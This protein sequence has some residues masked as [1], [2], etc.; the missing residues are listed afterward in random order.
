MSHYHSLADFDFDLPQDCIALHPASPRDSSRLLCVKPGAPFADHRFGDLPN[1]LRSG[2]LLVF[3][4]TRV[5]SARLI[6]QRVRGENRVNI[7]A[8]LLKRL[9]SNVWSAFAKPGK[10]LAIGDRVVF[11]NP[12]PVCAAAELVGT[13]RAKG[14]GGVVEIEFTR[15]GAYLDEAI[16]L[17]GAMPLPPYI[18]EA[19]RRSE[20]P[21]KNAP[22][23]TGRD[24][25]DYQTVFA[26]TDGAVAAPTASLHFTPELIAR[27]EA[28]GIAHTFVTLHVGAGTFLPVKDDNLEAHRMHAEWGEISAASAARINAARASGGRI[29]AVGTTACRLLESAADEGGQVRPFCAETDI[30]IKPGYRFRATDALITNFHLPKSTLLMLVSAF[31]GVKT[32]REAYAHA[33]KTGYRFYSYGD[34]SLLFS[35]QTVF[36]DTA[37]P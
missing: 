32:M 30:F 35:A 5:I 11:G 2:D 31:S 17:V 23:D 22:A 7:E 25:R 3:N 12:N 1:L 21:A 28:A 26:R 16:A 18:L 14:E 33:I 27:L 34:S 13:L 24:A 15:D 37:K 29:V 36:P 10:R 20:A 19:R 4:D 9:A 6:G 8:L